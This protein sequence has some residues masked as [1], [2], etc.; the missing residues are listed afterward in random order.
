MLPAVTTPAE[1]RRGVSCWL[2]HPSLLSPSS[3]PTTWKRS[4]VVRGSPHVTQMETSSCNGS[5]LTLRLTPA[6]HRSPGGNAPSFSL[7]ELERGFSPEFARHRLVSNTYAMKV[8]EA[9]SSIPFALEN[10]YPK[11]PGY[12]MEEHLAPSTMFLDIDKMI[13]KYE[14]EWITNPLA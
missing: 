6:L 7:I 1:I 3:S 8:Q 11:Y 12:I 14:Q 4:R 9:G 2:G 10:E 13:G 5:T